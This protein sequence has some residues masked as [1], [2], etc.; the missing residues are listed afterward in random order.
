MPNPKYCWSCK[1][2]EDFGSRDHGRI[3]SKF[4]KEHLLQWEMSPIDGCKLLEI[5]NDPNILSFEGV[6]RKCGA[7]FEVCRERKEG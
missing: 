5:K 7:S 6:C 1:D 2:D 3:V 4:K